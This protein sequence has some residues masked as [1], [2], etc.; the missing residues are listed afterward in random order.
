MIGL[1][2]NAIRWG[3][4]GRQT[5]TDFPEQIPVRSEF[6]TQWRERI[7]WESVLRSVFFPRYHAPHK[8]W[9]SD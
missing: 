4:G 1:A 8:F 6:L 9:N 7:L 3:I 2:R 5:M